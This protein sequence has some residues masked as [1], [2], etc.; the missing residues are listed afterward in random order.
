MELDCSKEQS[1][2]GVSLYFS[3]L[4]VSIIL[5]SEELASFYSTND[6]EAAIFR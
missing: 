3:I 5:T 2:F 6:L 4:L 1:V